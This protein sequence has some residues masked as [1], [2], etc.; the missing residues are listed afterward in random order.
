MN[1][2]L[3]A[4]PSKGTEPFEVFLSMI[5]ILNKIKQPLKIPSAFFSLIHYNKSIFDSMFCF[6]RKNQKIEN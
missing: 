1:F 4:E 6:L 2:I 5:N 3:R